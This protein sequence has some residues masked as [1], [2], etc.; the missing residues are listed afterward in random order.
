M[1]EI[2]SRKTQENS[3][4]SEACIEFKGVS[5]RRCGEVCEQDAIRFRP[6]GRGAYHPVL[7]INQ[8]TLCGEC[9]KMCPV[10][11]INLITTDR[12]ALEQGCVESG[13]E[14]AGGNECVRTGCP[15]RSGA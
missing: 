7:D 4:I 8:C 6:M 11:A 9:L 12:G 5:C 1:P 15:P 14:N 13:G 3:I 10:N 2:P